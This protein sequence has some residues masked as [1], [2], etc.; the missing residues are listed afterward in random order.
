[1]HPDPHVDGSGETSS[2]GPG[3]KPQT[4]ESPQLW[5][6]GPFIDAVKG[7]HPGE[8][9]YIVGK[10][11]SLV[12]LTEEAFGPGPVICLNRAIVHVQELG[13][14]NKLYSMQKD[15]CVSY[16][17][18][19]GGCVGCGGEVFPIVYPDES[20]TLLLH[21]H[22]SKNCLPNHADRLVFDAVDELGFGWW[23]TSSPCAIRIAKIFGCEKVVLLCHDSLFDEY[24][25]ADIQDGK[26][27]GLEEDG[28][29]AENYGPITRLVKQELA[30]IAHEVVRPIPG[31][32]AD[33]LGYEYTHAP[34]FAP[35]HRFFNTRK[36]VHF[37]TASEAEKADVIERLPDVYEG[38]AYQVNITNAANCWPL[39]RFYNMR[40]GAHFYTASEAEKADVMARLGDV[41]RL[42]GVAHTVCLTPVPGATPVHR[43]HNVR[44]GAHFYT[45][46]EAEKADVISTLSATHTYEGIAYYLAP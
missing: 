22:E 13:L 14:G 28:C 17:Q 26:A 6:S 19:D 12:D 21:E 41:Y 25:T 36:G 40:N 32:G 45:A 44:T 38:V 34:S 39:Y 18:R 43:F 4:G 5:R 31:G 23:S 35:V 27:V 42:E 33:V 15:G 7:R 3:E 30:G 11:P 20:V 16:R 46:S 10:G 8:T 9:C 29:G 2:A 1:M 24:G 37:Y